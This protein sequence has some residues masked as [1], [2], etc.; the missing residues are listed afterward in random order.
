MTYSISD[1]FSTII[2]I[3]TSTKISNFTSIFFGCLP[4]CQTVW[5]IQ[6]K[7]ENEQGQAKIFQ[8]KYFES[9]QIHQVTI[10]YRFE[11]I[12]HDILLNCLF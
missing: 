1:T 11:Q 8:D 9:F 4:K 10:M 2:N 3:S 7:Y 6:L 12:N 5:L